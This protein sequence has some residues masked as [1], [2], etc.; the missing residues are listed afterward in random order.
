MASLSRT[1]V[2][3]APL[4]TPSYRSFGSTAVPLAAAKGKTRKS[5]LVLCDQVTVLM[6]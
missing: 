2:R 4:S 1:A 6:K 5:A 3:I